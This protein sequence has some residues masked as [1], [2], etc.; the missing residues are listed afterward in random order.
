[1]KLARRTHKRSKPLVKN[2]KLARRA[3]R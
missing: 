2:V 1:V 3:R